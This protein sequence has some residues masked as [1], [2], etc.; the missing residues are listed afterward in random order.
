MSDNKSKWAE[1]LTPEQRGALRSAH[2]LL[3]TQDF[4]RAADALRAAFARKPREWNGW[5]YA[6]ALDLPGPSTFSPTE[7]DGWVRVRVIEVLDDE[8]AS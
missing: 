6:D 5:V 1:N 3:L 7:R 8:A 2:S 4:E